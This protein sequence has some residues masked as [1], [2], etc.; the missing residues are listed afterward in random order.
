MA[1]NKRFDGRKFDEVREMEAKVGIIP[2]AEGSAMFRTGKTVAIAAVY[3]PRGVFPAF[4]Q[5]PK[6]GRL[7]C[8]YDLLSFSVTERK[9]PGPSR[10]STEISMVTEDSL[11]PVLDLTKFSYLGVDVYVYITQADAG[12]RA[13]GINAAAL[14]LA[15]AGMSMKD[16]ITSIAVGKV[17]DK[18]VVDLDKDEEDHEDGATDLPMAMS[19]RTGEITLLQMDGNMTQK[20]I[21]EAVEM[22]MKAC[23]DIKKVQVEALKAKYKGA[24]K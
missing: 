3:G 15:D 10:R 4:L 8:V 11:K 17:S 23:L 7:K 14:A 20:E 22:G 2:R 1:Y 13:A 21:K 19:T 6:E 5:N 16:L 9:R 18:I 12:T 24:G